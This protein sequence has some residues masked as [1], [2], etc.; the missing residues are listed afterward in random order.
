M[1]AARGAAM[2]EQIRD[3]IREGDRD[4]LYHG[5]FVQNPARILGFDHSTY[6]DEESAD[7]VRVIGLARDFDQGGPGRSDP[8]SFLR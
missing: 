6:F 3:A 5:T 4:L 7:Q 2:T 1:L 8:G